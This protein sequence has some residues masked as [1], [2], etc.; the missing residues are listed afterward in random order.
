MKGVG[1]VI[2]QGNTKVFVLFSLR[3]NLILKKKKKGQKLSTSGKPNLSLT[4]P[5]LLLQLKKTA[6]LFISKTLNI[7]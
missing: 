6:K 5:C 4:V 1:M 7:F 3:K 2:P